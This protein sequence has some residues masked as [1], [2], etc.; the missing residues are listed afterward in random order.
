MKNCLLT[1]LLLFSFSVFGQQIMWVSNKNDIFLNSGLTVISEDSILESALDFYEIYGYYSSLKTSNR[2]DGFSEIENF[3]SFTE[4]DNK[5]WSELKKLF[6]EINTFTVICI[7]LETS[8]GSSA[9]I[10]FIKNGNYRLIHFSNEFKN[11]TTS[12]YNGVSS[13]MNDEKIRFIKFYKSMWDD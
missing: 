2:L 6:F 4:S 12:T 1:F 11:N 13:R 5:K 10:F 8:H 3:L 9:T 7:K